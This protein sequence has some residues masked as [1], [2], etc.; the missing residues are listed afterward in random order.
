MAP[1]TFFWIRTGLMFEPRGHD[2]MS[3]S[4]LY[5]PT[6]EDCDAGDPVHRDFGLP[7]DVRPRHDW[8]RHR[9]HR[10]RPGQAEVGGNVAARH[11][12]GHRRGALRKEWRSRRARADRQ[13]P[14]FLLGRGYNIEIDGLGELTVDVA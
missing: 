8:H 10:T 3:G 9:N 4:I 12:G 11:A 14:S 6:R 2:M 1:S 7:A 5:P 13:C